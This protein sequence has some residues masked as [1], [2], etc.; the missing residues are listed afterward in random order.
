MEQFRTG[1]HALKTGTYNGLGFVFSDD[2]PFTGID[3]DNCILNN[4]IAPAAEALITDLWSYTELSP[5]HTGVHI[6]VAGTIP[7]GRRK[8]NI[9]MYSKER[10]FTL[11][12][13]HLKGSPETI[14]ERQHQLDNLYAQ[15]THQQPPRE[16]SVYV[17]SQHDNA[18]LEKAEKAKNG[19][20]FTALYN[21]NTA[22]FRSKSEADFTLV[23]RL[24]YWTNDDIEQTKRLF[25]QSGLYDP[26]KTESPRGESTYLD[27]TIS[28]ALK[29]RRT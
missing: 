14:E 21:G 25:K 23:L 11:T 12:T 24:L 1:Q 7:E 4:C 22:G 17:Q 26:E 29:K 20:S 9:E 8:G 19:A 27:V 3:I 6:L 16:H 28:N 5:S 10:Y 15:L 13:H 18:V 2:D